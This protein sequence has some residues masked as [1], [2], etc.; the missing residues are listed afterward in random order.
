MLWENGGRVTIRDNIWYSHYEQKGG[1]S[2][3]FVRKFYNLSYQ[4]AVQMLLDERIE[5]LSVTVEQK[6]EK[7]P[8]E[9][10]PRNDTMRQVFAYLL[11]SRFL[12]RDVVKHFVH[13]GL[14]YE[15][16]E[17]HKEKEIHNCVFFGVDKDGI[18]I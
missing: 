4:D 12:D 16:K 14:I 8:F 17:T 1:N 5:S 7:K 9:L 6:K 11:N 18:Y 15:S 13:E 10:P 3:E 2:I